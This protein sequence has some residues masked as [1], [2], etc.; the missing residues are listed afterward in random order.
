[1]RALVLHDGELS[2]ATRPTP[3]PGPGDVV[4][5]VR[6]AGVNAADLLQRR[7]LYAA[8][9]GWPPDVPGLE[10]A[11]VVDDIGDGVD[12]ALRGRRVCAVVGGGAHATHCL[13]PAPHLIPVPDSAT[14]TEAGGFSEAFL[15]AHDA[16]VSQA[17]V[18]PGE[19]VLISGAAG[20]VGVAAV[21][22]ARLLGANVTAVTRTPEHHQRLRDVGAT[23]AITADDETS[24]TPVDVVIELVGAAHLEAVQAI[25]APRARI[26]VIG[27]GSGARAQID[28][29]R[30]MTLRA[31]L[32]GSTLRARSREEKTEVTE[33]ACATLADAWSRGVLRVPV[34][35]TFD[36]AEAAAAYEYFSRPGKFG[37]VV[38]VVDAAP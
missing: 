19:H 5:A 36:L 25:L 21:Q 2:L 8:P 28:L 34:A 38:L 10:V 27:V 6:A 31:T 22:V 4:V 23:L 1:M 29:R 16:L 24:L 3:E 32:T 18:R 37:K 13:V 15:T 33:R 35:R 14:W 26:V 30:V 17:H 12:P 7:G 11:G 9:D 20:G